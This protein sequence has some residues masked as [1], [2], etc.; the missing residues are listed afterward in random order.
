MCVCDPPKSTDIILPFILYLIIK[1]KKKQGRE[2]VWVRGNKFS[3]SP[4]IVFCT[5][6]SKPERQ[7]A[8]KSIFEIFYKERV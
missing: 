4:E 3:I 2:E 8:K 1:E 6:R 5:L 7:N